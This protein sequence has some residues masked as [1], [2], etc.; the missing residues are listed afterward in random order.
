MRLCSV[1]KPARWAAGPVK[2]LI[3]R[4]LACFLSLQAASF[5]ASG[6]HQRQGQ[7]VKQQG[8]EAAWML[9]I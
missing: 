9:G 8:P 6:R 2:M 3:P 4:L 5:V 1:L 7:N